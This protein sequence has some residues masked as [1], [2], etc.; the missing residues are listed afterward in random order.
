[1][2]TGPAAGLGQGEQLAYWPVVSF[3]LHTLNG[4]CASPQ[5]YLQHGVYAVGH[6]AMLLRE[7][8]EVLKVDVG[9]GLA[10]R[11]EQ[12]EEILYNIWLV[13]NFNLE[14]GREADG[15]LL[16]DGRRDV[17]WGHT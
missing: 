5:I 1:M 6:A 7:Q 12:A 13:K 16:G 8:V 2:I 9:V 14:G 4:T 15:G 10:V 17:Q 11:Q 3:G